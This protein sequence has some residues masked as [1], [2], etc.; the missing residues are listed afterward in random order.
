LIREL[1]SVLLHR[2]LQ[3]SFDYSLKGVLCKPT[4]FEFRWPDGQVLKHEGS[5]KEEDHP[6]KIMKEL[7]G[8]K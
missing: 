3:D 1:R 8:D 7:T 6:F 4:C 2:H 5:F